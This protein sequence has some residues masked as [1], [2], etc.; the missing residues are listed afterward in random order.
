MVLLKTYLRPVITDALGSHWGKLVFSVIH[1]FYYIALFPL[2]LKLI[3][4]K[5]SPEQEKA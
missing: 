2:A 3:G 5:L 1:A 4:K